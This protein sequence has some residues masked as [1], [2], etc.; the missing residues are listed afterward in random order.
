[1]KLKDSINVGRGRG[2]LKPSLCS[3]ERVVGLHI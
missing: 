3:K 2:E 1:M